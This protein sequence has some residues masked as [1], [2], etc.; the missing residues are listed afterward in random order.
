[1][2]AGLRALIETIREHADATRERAPAKAARPAKKPQRTP[3]AKR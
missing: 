3:V 2:P 1:V